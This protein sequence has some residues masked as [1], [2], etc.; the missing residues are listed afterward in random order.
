MRARTQVTLQIHTST[1]QIFPFFG[2]KCQKHKG[3]SQFRSS[4][5]AVVPVAYFSCN[6]GVS[7]QC[8]IWFDF[9]PKKAQLIVKVLQQAWVFSLLLLDGH[10]LTLSTL[11]S[12]YQVKDFPIYF[13][14]KLRTQSQLNFLQI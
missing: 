7:P 6:E 10:L 5:L 3:H 12:T 11:V 14:L 1:L 8:L 2:H 13:S 4:L 9:F